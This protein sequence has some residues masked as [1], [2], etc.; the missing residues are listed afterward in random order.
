[1]RRG[2]THSWS[3]PFFSYEVRAQ[4]L[5]T[6]YPSNANKFL[7][8]SSLSSSSSSSPSASSPVSSSST[9]ARANE[10]EQALCALGR[11]RAQM[12]REGAILVSR[13]CFSR[14]RTEVA[15]HDWGARWQRFGATSAGTSMNRVPFSP[16]C[17]LVRVTRGV[18]WDGRSWAT[19]SI[20]V[21]S[22]RLPGIVVNVDVFSLWFAQHRGNGPSS[23][24][25]LPPSF[26]PS[27]LSSLPH[28]PSP[29]LPRHKYTS[30]PHNEDQFVDMPL[31]GEH[32]GA[33]R[34]RRERRMRSCWRH[35]QMSIQKVLATVQHHSYG[36]RGQPPGREERDEKYCT[37][38]FWK[39]LSP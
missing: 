26:P 24:T 31:R 4:R 34:V 11:A 28:P 5:D 2:E 32:A 12:A 29:P 36:T 17:W 10:Q 20:Q 1:M 23:L 16:R 3:R 7:K 15:V 18:S 39:R 22:T 6:W 14:E 25:S 19:W 35:E 37:A 30:T 13:R 21:G 9:C 38:T 27:P 8:I 33:A